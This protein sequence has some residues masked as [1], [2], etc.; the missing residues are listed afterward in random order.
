MHLST[1]DHMVSLPCVLEKK[2]DVK[3]DNVIVTKQNCG[4]G[5]YLFIFKKR[6][7]ALFTKTLQAPVAGWDLRLHSSISNIT[8]DPSITQ[9]DFLCRN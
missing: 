2:K 8:K 7:S 9:H 5:N 4:A 1:T 6:I 3:T